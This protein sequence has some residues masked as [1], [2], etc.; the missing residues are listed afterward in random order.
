MILCPVMKNR[1]FP[2]W[3][4]PS[5]IISIGCIDLKTYHKHPMRKENYWKIQHSF[6]L[7]LMI[8]IPFYVSS[9]FNISNKLPSFCFLK[10]SLSFADFARVNI[11]KSLM[12]VPKH[13]VY[14]E[15]NRSLS[16][17]IFPQIY[18]TLFPLYKAIV[19]LFLSFWYFIIFLFFDSPRNNLLNRFFR[20]KKK[21]FSFFQNSF[22]WRMWLLLILVSRK[23][24]GFNK[25]KLQ[26]QPTPMI[27]TLSQ[28]SRHLLKMSHT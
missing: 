3:F 7:L 19:N 10:N 4:R 22:N 18:S 5:L 14:R 8:S 9:L 25:T 1:L 26:I 2:K 6:I 15:L 13:S 11:T 23:S 21:K 27:A 28:I 20:I 17:I 16:E 24:F 12:L